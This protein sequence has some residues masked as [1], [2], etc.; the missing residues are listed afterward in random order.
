MI[1]ADNTSVAEPVFQVLSA[2][3]GLG[4]CIARVIYALGYVGSDKP[5]GNGRLIGNWYLLSQ[6]GLQFAA[7]LTGYKMIT[8]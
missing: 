3:L 4:W 5:N 1:V 2:G 6:L 8:G 7:G